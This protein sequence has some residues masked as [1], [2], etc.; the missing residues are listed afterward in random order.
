MAIPFSVSADR[1]LEGN[2]LPRS[3]VLV[4]ETEDR[5]LLVASIPHG[6][7]FRIIPHAPVRR[8]L[9]RSDG[10]VQSGR[11]PHRANMAM[12]VRLRE[13]LPPTLSDDVGDFSR[14]V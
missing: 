4:P 12:Q 7:D 2:E 3:L 5:W 6:L 11:Q 10:V 9:G 1:A 13:A 14:D 8:R